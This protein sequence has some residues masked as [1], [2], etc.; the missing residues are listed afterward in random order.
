[1]TSDADGFWHQDPDNG[2]TWWSM[3][4]DGEFYHQNGAGVFWAWSDYDVG[5]APPEERKEPSVAQGQEHEQGLLRQERKVEGPLCFCKRQD[6]KTSSSSSTP[7][8]HA[9]N[10][11]EAMAAVGSRDRRVALFVAIKAMTLGAALNVH[12][13]RVETKDAARPT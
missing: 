4:D 3:S 10:P 13:G 2:F 12:P 7:T 11:G 8:F 1:M 5:A 6:G 9:E